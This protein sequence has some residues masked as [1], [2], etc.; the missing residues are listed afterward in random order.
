MGGKGS[1]P[2]APD[3]V[4]AANAQSAA[5]Q[6]L[7]T[8]QTWANRPDQNTPWGSQFWTQQATVD[9]ATG[10][11]VTAWTQNQTLD[12][13]LQGALNDQLA[14][15]QGRTSLAG[16][17]MD[18]VADE[19]S[20][21]FNWASLPG[22]SQTPQQQ[23]TYG[24][25]LQTYIPQYNLDTSWL[26]QTT[27][28]WQGVGITGQDTGGV[29]P[30]SAAGRYQVSPLTH[31]YG[32]QISPF[33]GQ[34][35]YQVA[36]TGADISAPQQTTYGTNEAAFAA[37]RQR[38]EEGLFNRMRPEQQ[39]QE[40]TIR[41][42]LANQGLTA[43]SEAYNRE[44]Q[45][46]HEQQAGERYN[47][48]MTGGQEQQRLH[49]MLMGQQ[50]QA[51]G[52]DVTSQQAQNAALQQLF[53]QRM[54]AGQFALGQEQ[55]A[56]GQQLGAAQFGLGQ[57]QQAFG[58]Q[59]GAGQFALG[60]EQQAFGQ[61]MGSQAQ[62]NQALQT[63]FGQQMGAGQFG[64]QAQQQAFGQQAAAQ[65]AY[66]Q[67]LMQQFGQ[68]LQAGQF[69][70][71]AQQQMFSQDQTAN[72]QNWAQML[73]AAQ[74]QNQLRQQAIAEQQMSRGMSLNE[75]NALLTGQQVG[76]PGMPS[77]MGASTGQAPNLLGAAQ[78]QGQ[79]GLNAANMDMQGD[80][81]MW[82]G[83]GQLAGMA[84]M[85]FM[86]DVRL[87]S[88]IKRVGTHPFG[89]G[90]YEYDIFG[91]RE[92]GVMAQE[93]LAVRPDLVATHPSGYLMVNYGGL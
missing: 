69:G 49:S 68:G 89:V 9:P 64:L 85:M 6:E 52:Q 4:G 32:Y 41:T 21:P 25:N 22:M 29:A 17:F 51:F 3:Y 26:Q 82:N 80:Q 78:S 28:P 24:R 34:N 10:Q 47:A 74:F 55:Q 59:L 70:N 37:E 43:G 65:Q 39:R 87:K 12:P 54:G 60:Q 30:T 73:Q 88:N 13:A 40:D 61:Q 53:N 2:P 71:Q 67:A 19:Y 11:S 48:L 23:F 35:E 62:R 5:S 76:T 46:L 84:A 63:L 86:S 15:Q 57:Q 33:T 38:I 36:P 18:R 16:S 77:F 31:P 14:I 90:I 42:M 8:Q 7:A 79:Y 66:N 27:N 1:A 45:R 91:E 72:Q 58:Q 20:Q 81:A 56:F 83:I 93:L 50:Q 92:R 44:L 75:L